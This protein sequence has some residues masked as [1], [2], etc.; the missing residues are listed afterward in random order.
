MF[1]QQNTQI[2]SELIKLGILFFSSLVLACIIYYL[3]INLAIKNPDSS[4]SSTYECGFEPYED[5]RNIFDVR[6]YLIA[7]LFLI[8]D[9]ESI[10]FYP[11]TTVLS[12]LNEQGFWLMLDF[13]V[14]LLVGYVYAWRIEALNWM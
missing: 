9:L 11:W 13:A 2:F 10:Y 3:S 12:L 4:K 14:E 8:F 7:I 5:A 1:L 6:F